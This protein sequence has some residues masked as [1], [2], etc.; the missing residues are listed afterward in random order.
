MRINKNN[1]FARYYEWIYGSL[2]DDL[3]SFFWGTLYALGL[4][5]ILVVGR[6][7]LERWGVNVWKCLG[8]GIL[9]W[10]AYGFVI[11]MGL[12][13]Y[14]Q[15][16]LDLEDGFSFREH[17]HLLNLTWYGLLLGM[18]L[19]F[20]GALLVCIAIVA[21]PVSLIWLICKLFKVTVS[22]T[23]AQNTKDLVG[24][25]RGKYCTRINWK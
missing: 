19:V 20:I 22:T 11:T 12:V 13:M 8:A 16:I 4:S 25:I 18:P 14:A 1:L 9:T 10:L 5:P 24:S 15:Y 17:Y 2:P 21:I 7:W 23:L 6:L 3:C